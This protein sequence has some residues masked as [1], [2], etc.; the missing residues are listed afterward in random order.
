MPLEIHFSI[1]SSAS[2]RRPAQ[3]VFQ[4]DRSAT[5]EDGFP[6]SERLLRDVEAATVITIPIV[7]HFFCMCDGDQ[8]VCPET[9]LSDR[10][11]TVTVAL[12]NRSTLNNDLAFLGRIPL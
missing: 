7:R 4:E 3:P 6:G 11:I 5:I 12:Q 9:R 1:R 2:Q 10:E 8:A